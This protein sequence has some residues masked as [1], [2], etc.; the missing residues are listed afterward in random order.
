[1]TKSHRLVADEMVVVVAEHLSP[2]F[3]LFRI[4][5][6]ECLKLDRRRTR[7]VQ[8]SP[9]GLVEITRRREGSTRPN[10]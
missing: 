7:I 6:R 4:K 3:K 10:R 5:H 8:I 9:S 2:L 1:M